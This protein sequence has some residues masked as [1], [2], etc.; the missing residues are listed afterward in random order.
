MN[1]NWMLA[2]IVIVAWLATPAFAD[3][4]VVDP[5]VTKAKPNAVIDIGKTQPGETIELII[6]AD[7]SYGSE[8]P[9]EQAVFDWSMKDGIFVE[10]SAVGTKSL[11][12]TIHTSA[13]TPIGMYRVPLIMVGKKEVLE[14]EEYV[15]QFGVEKNLVQGSISKAQVEGAVNQPLS[16]RVLLVNDSSASAKI[17]VIPGL[18]ASWSREKKITIKPLSFETTTIT[19]VPRFAGKKTFDIRIFHENIGQEV[20]TLEGTLTANP[21]F[22]DRYAAGFFGFPFYTI[23][24]VSGY[25]TN[26]LFSLLL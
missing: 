16:F 12:T 3:I 19:V 18:P 11:I 2:G 9:W 6:S 1:H 26:A 5:M 17:K 13:D 22:K 24:I 14:N 10:N 8:A 15:I 25:L 7:S 20:S 23:S 21:S 4:F